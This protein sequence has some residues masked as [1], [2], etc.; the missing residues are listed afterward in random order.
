[1]ISSVAMII[2]GLTLL[3]RGDECEFS[4]LRIFMEPESMDASARR[5]IGLEKSHFPRLR[6]I[7]VIIKT[8]PGLPSLGHWL[9]NRL[10][11]YDDN[12]AQEVNI[13]ALN[14]RIILDTRD[15]SRLLRVADI[16][17]AETLIVRRVSVFS[18]ATHAKLSNL[19]PAVEIA[20]GEDGEILHL[21]VTRLALFRRAEDGSLGLAIGK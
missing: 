8:N 12:V 17:D 5:V 19:I 4:L 18:I 13:L 7:A 6:R 1:M 14:A 9:T 11:I 16:D 3:C 20:V 21:P 2:S 10:L 15:D